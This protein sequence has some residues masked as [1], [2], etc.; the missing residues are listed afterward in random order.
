M[1]SDL[2]KTNKQERQFEKFDQ[3]YG[4][5][6]ALDFNTGIGNHSKDG[7]VFPRWESKQMHLGEYRITMTKKIERTKKCISM[8][9]F[10]V[11]GG[12]GVFYCPPM[13]TSH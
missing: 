6:N 3:S 5:K 4:Q 2:K 9:R 13:P 10:Q 11:V 12:N 1:F 7:S 8:D